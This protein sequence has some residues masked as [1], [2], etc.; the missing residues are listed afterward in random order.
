MLYGV[1]D[2]STSGETF[3]DPLVS[4][5]QAAL[6]PAPVT[7]AVQPTV[8]STQVA[9]TGWTPLLVVAGAGVA[10]WLWKG[11]KQWQSGHISF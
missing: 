9:S 8:Q 1:I 3:I 5:A 4:Q 10:W 2:Y 6:T 7:A 11:K